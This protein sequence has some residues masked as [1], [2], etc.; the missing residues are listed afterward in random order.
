MLLSFIAGADKIPEYCILFVPLFPAV[1]L[2]KLA[3]MPLLA[4]ML[5]ILLME[6]ARNLVVKA[7]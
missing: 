5:F 4:S 1:S 3:A 6:F 2:M 7:D